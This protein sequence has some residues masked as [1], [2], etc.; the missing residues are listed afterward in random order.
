MLRRTEGYLQGASGKRLFRRAWLPEAPTRV[1][2][3]VHGFGEHCG[4]YEEM[5]AW[6]AERV[7]RVGLHRQPPAKI[8]QAE[9]RDV[10]AAVDVVQ[11]RREALI[12]GDQQQ[13][14]VA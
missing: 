11:H 13:L 12:L 1:V 2:V 8:G 4:R 6:L 14:S 3:L 7:E 5:A 10:V 9:G